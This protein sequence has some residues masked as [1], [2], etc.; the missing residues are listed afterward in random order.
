MPFVEDSVEPGSEVHT[1]GWLGYEPPFGALAGSL[2]AV[3][4]AGIALLMVSSVPYFSQKAVFIPRG[5]AYPALVGAVLGLVV[6]LLY[7]EPAMFTIGVI[8]VLSG[9]VRLARRL[10]TERLRMAL[11]AQAGAVPPASSSSAEPSAGVDEHPGESS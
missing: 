6:L 1:D 9:P 11:R 3:G 10:R 4:F 5:M 2:L 8:Y 7:H